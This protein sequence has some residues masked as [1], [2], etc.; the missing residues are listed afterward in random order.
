MS[1]TFSL[2][3]SPKESRAAASLR[4]D[5][6]HRAPD[7]HLRMEGYN[8]APLLGITTVCKRLSARALQDTSTAVAIEDAPEI[9]R[10][11]AKPLDEC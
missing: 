8:L 5:T 9:V 1:N 2:T 11:F 4:S 10:L 7:R 6:L 3:M